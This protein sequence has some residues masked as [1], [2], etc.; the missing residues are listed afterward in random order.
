MVIWD[1]VI[2]PTHVN[3]LRICFLNF[4]RHLY[5]FTRQL[6]VWKKNT[7]YYDNRV[8]QF[9]PNRPQKW[10]FS[11]FTP[12]NFLKTKGIAL[13]LPQLTDAI[14]SLK[15]LCVRKIEGDRAHYL[16]CVP[17]SITWLYR[18]DESCSFGCLF[19]GYQISRL[20]YLSEFKSYCI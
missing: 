20:F 6:W 17:R 12:R 4:T 13:E 16:A 10:I 15:S 9:G 5:I 14:I 19:L 8:Q 2:S 18:S 3:R 1:T 7:T 11:K